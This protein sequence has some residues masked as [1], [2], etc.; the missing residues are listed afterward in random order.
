MEA[1]KPPLTKPDGRTP[2]SSPSDKQ[3]KTKTDIFS[4][5]AKWFVLAI[6]IIPRFLAS[7]MEHFTEAGSVGAVALGSLVFV[8]GV[9][10]TADSYWQSL[11]QGAAL[12]PFFEQ[13]WVGW[14]WLPGFTFFPLRAWAGIIFNPA[15]I[16]GYEY[17]QN[18][19]PG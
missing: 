1:N 18:R 2:L 16:L 12:M 13:T 6:S 10:L 7:V 19:K 9:L 17:H 5:I 14:S 3:Q 15:F 4:T 8:V 11:F